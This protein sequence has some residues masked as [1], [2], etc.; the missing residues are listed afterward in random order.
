MMYV[1]MRL[2]HSGESE[3][4]VIF[5]DYN[6]PAVT[7]TALAMLLFSHSVMSDS[8]RPHGL[9]HTRPL[10]P[11]PSPGVH[12]SSCP[13]YQWCHPA[14]S[15]SDT[16]FSFCPQ[17]FP[18]S[19]TFP[20]SQLF[21]SDDQNTGVSA[22]ASA[23]PMSTQGWFPLR[24]NGLASLL[25][26]VLSGALAMPPPKCLQFSLLFP[27]IHLPHQAFSPEVSEIQALPL[28]L[29]PCFFPPLWSYLVAYR[30]LVPQPE[31]EPVPWAVKSWSPNHWTAREF[32]I[33]DSWF[34]RFGMK[35]R[36]AISW[37]LRLG[38]SDAGGLKMMLWAAPLHTAARWFFLKDMITSHPSLEPFCVSPT[39]KVE[40]KLFI[41]N[42]SPL[43]TYFLVPYLPIYFLCTSNFGH[44]SM[45]DQQSLNTSCLFLSHAF[46]F[47]CSVFSTSYH[48]LLYLSLMLAGEFPSSVN[49]P[50]LYS[51]PQDPSLHKAW[52]GSTTER[53]G[54]CVF[55]G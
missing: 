51:N 55:M 6:G 8:F 44:N 1:G 5:T 17:S 28:P 26:K 46:I 13:L 41:M 24:L 12:P 32:L 10:C 23:F 37:T 50:G 42:Y 43:E 22:S 31:T 40:S 48:W 20:M 30:I 2:D 52:L 9:Q 36:Q 33:R 16:F 27:S 15:S 18:A 21:T 11:S 25:S 14:I 7:N 34:G 29:W 39:Y 38:D 19:G 3:I 35:P 49:T 4:F 53:K 54:D 45:V 47:G